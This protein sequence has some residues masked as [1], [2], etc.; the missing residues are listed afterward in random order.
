MMRALSCA[1]LSFILINCSKYDEVI[2]KGKVLAYVDNRV[3]TVQDFLRRSEYSIRPDYCRQS[4]YLHKKIVLNSLIAEKLTSLEMSENDKLFESSSFNKFLKGRKE[5][6]MR[7]VFYS[8]SFYDSISISDSEINK[9]FRYSG[10]TIDINYLSLPTI[11]MVRSF[12]DLIDTGLTLDS[13]FVYLWQQEVPSRKVNWFDREPDIIHEKLFNEDL[14]KGKIIG[15][16]K[17]DDGS[18]LVIEV[19]G[20]IDQPAIK[21]ED[22]ELRWNDTKERIVERMASNKYKSYVKKIMSGK[23][24]ILQEDA[25]NAYAVIAGDYYLKDE[26]QKKIALNQAIW[27]NVEKNAFHSNDK[28]PELNLSKKIFNFDDRDYSINDLNEM[29]KSHPLVFRKRKMNKGEFRSQLKLAIADLLRDEVIT[30]L[31]Y[32]KG[33]ENDWRVELNVDLWKDAY[34]SRR[35]REIHGFNGSETNNEILDYLNPIVD[36]LQEKYSEKIKINMDIFENIQITSTD[37]FVTQRGLPYPIIVPS[38]PILT[39][40]NRLDYGSK[41]E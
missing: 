12:E 41:L 23:K 37:M 33:F 27:D 28:Y 21:T 14:E 18:Y 20:W 34:A 24:L 31:C 1:I 7:Q 30:K 2:E 5:Q 9:H 19:N 38:F 32:D 25:F 13:I 22:K 10:R 16:F 11:E 26:K 6:A 8:D 35:F 36:S 29:I 39:S 15:P 17:I 3:I 4:N 40:D